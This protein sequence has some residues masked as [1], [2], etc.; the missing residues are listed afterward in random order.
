M[1]DEY[2][3]ELISWSLYRLNQFI[4]NVCIYLNLMYLNRQVKL[5]YDI[6]RVHLY[7]YVYITIIL[8]YKRGAHF[9][10]GQDKECI[11]QVFFRMLKLFSSLRYLAQSFILF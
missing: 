3:A 2:K 4:S 10:N 9:N 5:K 11:F 6:Q 8:E 7:I 1:S